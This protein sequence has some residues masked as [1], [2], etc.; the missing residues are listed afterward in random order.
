[1]EPGARGC[2]VALDRFRREVHR[3]GRFFDRESGEIAHLDDLSLPRAQRGEPAQCVVQRQELRGVRFGK[4]ELWTE[5][6]IKARGCSRRSLPRAAHSCM[7]D[8][9]RSHQMRGRTQEMRAILIIDL[10][11]PEQANPQFVYKICGHPSVRRTF[12]AQTSDRKP[13]QFRKCQAGQIR[14]SRAV[15]ILNPLEQ[16]RHFAGNRFQTRHLQRLSILTLNIEIVIVRPATREDL[17]AISRIQR[18]S[19]E[20]SAWEPRNDSC[21]VAVVD[22][23]IAGFLVVRRTAPDEAEILNLAVD[24]CRRRQGIARALVN[25]ALQTTSAQWFLEVRESNSPAIALYRSL[26][27]EAVGRRENYYADPAEAAIVMRIHS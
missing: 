17:P 20:A 6:Q 10:F 23:S 21:S 9:D 27:F 19:P 15:P 7:I 24:P 8:D 14:N 26:G 18:L 5:I 25:F 1:M 16:D 12:M 22:G 4:I 13:A 11:A 3:L 2:P